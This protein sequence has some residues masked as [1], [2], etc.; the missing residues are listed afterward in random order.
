MAQISLYWRSIRPFSLT[1][2]FIPPILGSIIAVWQNPDLS[3]SWFHFLLTLVGCM[4]SHAGANTLSDY[5]D[6]KKRVDR[7]G[8]YGSSGVL[9]EK[10][11]SPMQLLR[12]T[13]ILFVTSTVIGA[14]LVQHSPN[15]SSLLWLIVVGGMLGVFYTMG[16]FQFKYFALGDPAV[17]IAFGS[18]MTLG[19]YMVQTGQFA[20]QPVLYAFPVALLVDA[21]L[22][23]NNLRDIK[24]DRMVHIKTIPILI[25]EPAAK[26]MYYVLIFG[27]YA[28][29]PVLIILAKLPW[30]SLLT[31]ISLPMAI[32]AATMVHNKSNMPEK[33]FAMIDAVTAQLHS[34]F[35]VLLIVALLLTY[36]V[37]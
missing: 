14:Y 29:I 11:M 13:A 16:P 4:T 2:S 12:W 5:F 17:F 32:K 36:L 20:W 6:Y 15:G 18:G 37:L 30:L 9:V 22:H 10:L 24:N 8:T 7:E 27:A 33:Q 3:F 25:G 1:V 19:A 34:V 21:V 26:T 28:L 35:S 31:L 23:S